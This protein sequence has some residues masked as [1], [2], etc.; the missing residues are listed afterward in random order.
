MIGIFSVDL[1]F[2]S[3]HYSKREGNEDHVLDVFGLVGTTRTYHQKMLGYFS[4]IFVI[5]HL[6]IF[7]IIYKEQLGGGPGL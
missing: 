2:W 1:W 7:L 3:K 5:K 6:I 4:S